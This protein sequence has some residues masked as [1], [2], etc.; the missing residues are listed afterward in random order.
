VTRL[1]PSSLHG[2]GVFAITNI[3]AGTK[4]FED[5]S[6]EMAWVSVAE[7]KLRGLPK[8]LKHLYRDFAVIKN[9][10]YGCPPNFNR[11]T[12]AWYLNES[13]PP[14]VR[15]DDQYDFYAARDI[16][17]GGG[18]NCGL[19]LVQRGSPRPGG[20]GAAEEGASKQEPETLSESLAWCISVQNGV[21]FKP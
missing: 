8:D 14:N 12:V 4:L 21:S 9:G 2:V 18:A 1:Q 17:K 19:R 6:N 20:A 15:C 5:D 7:R 10:Q 3:T 13:K 11:L 16:R